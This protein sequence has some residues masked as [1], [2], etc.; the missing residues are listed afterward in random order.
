MILSDTNT[1]PTSLVSSFRSSKGSRFRTRVCRKLTLKSI[2]F[3]VPLS[4]FA[5]SPIDGTWKTNLDASTLSDHPVV[6]SL[7]NGTYDCD[8]C[9]P[10][11]HVT[12]DGSDQ[13]VAGLP[14]VTLAVKEINQH[15]IAIVMKKDGKT[16]S[17]Q[18]RTASDDGQ[19]MH[20]T[21]TL[22]GPQN[23]K[24]EVQESTAQ[25]IGSPLP[26]ANLTS[27]SWR[28]VK[29]S[30]SDNGLLTTFKET[31]SRLSMTTPT[32][33]NW[34]ANFDGQYYPVQGS[35]VYDSV[36]L[37][38]VDDRRIIV[39]LKQNGAIVRVQTITISADGKIMTT[40]SENKVAGRVST[41]VATKQ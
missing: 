17:D 40:V 5:Q 38:K 25:R 16:I 11:V 10:K 1:R 12:A 34:T 36:S 3:L 31:E 27:G 35:Y 15:T 32:G 39:T 41:W 24:P 22:Y 29:Q 6:F 4:L 7:I 23:P 13:P 21:N 26:G 20:V 19:T 28:T 18:I 2:V 33:V 30:G 37:K 8:T 9:V 14:Q